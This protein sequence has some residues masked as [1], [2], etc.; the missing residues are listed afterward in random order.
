MAKQYDKQHSRSCPT[1]CPWLCLQSH[2]LP[3]CGFD[4]ACEDGAIIKCSGGGTY[5]VWRDSPAIASS[6]QMYRYFMGRNI[7]LR[8]SV[9]LFGNLYFAIP[10][11]LQ[12]FSIDFIFLRFSSAFFVVF[13]STTYCA[14]AVLRIG[15]AILLHGGTSVLS[16]FFTVRPQRDC[17]GG[18]KRSPSEKN[19][20]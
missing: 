19:C 15:S 6:V 14:L 9:F 18:Q 1:L 12:F 2:P 10:S 3:F 8:L 17:S 5:P 4:A 7:L 13:S 11:F 20:L 16:T